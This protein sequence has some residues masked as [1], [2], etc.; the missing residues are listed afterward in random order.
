MAELNQHEKM[1]NRTTPIVPGE[2]YVSETDDRDTGPAQYAADLFK[3]YKAHTEGTFNRGYRERTGMN[4]TQFQSSMGNLLR[5]VVTDPATLAGTVLSAGYG[6][7][8]GGL[9][10][11]VKPVTLGL[12]REIVEEG[13]FTGG[14]ESLLTGP[15]YFT[16]PLEGAGYS[17]FDPQDKALEAIQQSRNQADVDVKEAA[18]LMQQ[19][20]SPISQSLL[21]E[22]QLAPRRR[23][24]LMNQMPPKSSLENL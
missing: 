19:Q 12:G 5:E 23:R 4:P 10:G 3:G 9:K 2:R 24:P 7:L 11:A 6:G 14:L 8:L 13:L 21:P 20:R 18:K 1:N 22:E 16:E 17:P 15:S